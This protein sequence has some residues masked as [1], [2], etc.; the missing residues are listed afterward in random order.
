MGIMSKEK[1]IRRDTTEILI[2]EQGYALV[3]NNMSPKLKD[4]GS[5]IIS[6]SLGEITF[7]HQFFWFIPL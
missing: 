2:K 3:Q 4:P 7:I 1:E 6:C 5:F